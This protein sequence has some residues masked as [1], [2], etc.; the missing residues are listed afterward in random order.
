MSDIIDKLKSSDE[1]VTNLELL[2]SENII[3]IENSCRIKR[4]Q[5]IPFKEMLK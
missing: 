5:F 1:Q 4:S 2:S 3:N